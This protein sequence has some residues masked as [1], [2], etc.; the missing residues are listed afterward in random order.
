MP[1]FPLFVDLSGQPVLVLGAGTVAARKIAVL[2]DFEAEVT[3]IAP[4]A[5]PEVAALSRDGRVR[6]IA[7]PYAGASDLEGVRLVIAAADDP[8]CNRAAAEDAAKL[9]TPFNAAD[10]PGLSTFYFPAVVKR[11]NVVIGIGTSGDLPAFSA[12]LRQKLDEGMP[13]DLGERI[14][15]I[16]EERRKQKR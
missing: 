9:G 6:W 2:L 12:A 11:G 15:R 4:R 13:E 8:S 14:E 5:A 1:Y 3:V 16:A 7:R 10:D